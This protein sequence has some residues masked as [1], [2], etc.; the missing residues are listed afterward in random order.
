MSKLQ[1]DPMCFALPGRV[2]RCSVKKWMGGSEAW[3]SMETK[4]DSRFC[5]IF[6][7]PLLIVHLRDFLMATKSMA[8]YYKCDE[9]YWPSDIVFKA[10][11]AFFVLESAYLDRRDIHVGLV[12]VIHPFEQLLEY[13][14]QILK[15]LGPKAAADREQLEHIASECKKVLQNLPAGREAM[16]GIAHDGWTEL[17]LELRRYWLDLIEYEVRRRPKHYTVPVMEHR[18]KKY[19]AA[20]LFPGS[21]P[22]SEPDGQTE[23][24]PDERVES[25][26]QSATDD[27]VTD[28]E[29][30]GTLMYASWA[31]RTCADSF[32]PVYER[33][34]VEAFE[35][36]ASIFASD[37]SFKSLA[38]CIDQS[39]RIL[40][41]LKSDKDHANLRDL[42][43]PQLW[44]RLADHMDRVAGELG[45]KYFAAQLAAKEK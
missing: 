20:I 44:D 30:L 38:P 8:A 32:S 27:V 25:D 3:P 10:S 23:S 45:D 43:P 36:F 42:A 40:V 4:Y 7:R 9:S 1:S 33:A 18:R 2:R 29:R 6:A 37:D 41:H 35:T 34:I 16:I 15:S 28:A 31:L 5:V 14:A 26:E 17:R 19:E 11:Q 22:E 12:K 13:L 21:E 39:Q 24:Q